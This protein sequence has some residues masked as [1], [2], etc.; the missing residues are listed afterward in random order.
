M[1]GT[2]RLKNDELDEPSALPAQMKGEELWEQLTK[3][4]KVGIWEADLVTGAVYWSS[5]VREI[6]GVG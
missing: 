2:I 3:I 1:V 6:H 5:E 4:A